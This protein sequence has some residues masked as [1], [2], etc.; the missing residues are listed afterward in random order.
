MPM[1]RRK[2]LSSVAG[3]GILTAAPSFTLAEAQ[4]ERATRATPI[5]RIK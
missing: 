2:F 5:P 1:P 3:V 4:T